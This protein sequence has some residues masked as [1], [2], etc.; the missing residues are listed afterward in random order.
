MKTH[1]LCKQRTN[2]YEAQIYRYSAPRYWAVSGNSGKFVAKVNLGVGFAQT[3]IAYQ[4]KAKAM[5]S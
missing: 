5:E 3:K 4:R 1:G 2:G